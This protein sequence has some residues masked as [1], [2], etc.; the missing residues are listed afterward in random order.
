MVTVVTQ[1]KSF[2]DGKLATLLIF[3]CVLA[4]YGLSFYKRQAS[5]DYWMNHPDEYVVEQVTAMSTH[6]A[7][8]WLKMAEDLDAGKTGKGL[9]DPLKEYPDLMGYPE[10]PSLLARFISLGTNFTGG[11]YYRAGLLLVPLLAGLFVFPL[12]IYCHTLGFGAS[13]ILGG[14]V[15]SFS[16]AYYSRSA[17]GCVDTDL[18]NLFFPLAVSALIVL[19]NRERALRS[20]LLLTLG[21]GL[22]MY[23]YNWWY[24]Q[25]SFILVYLVFIAA[26]LIF[27]RIPWKQTI[28]ILLIFPLACGP[29]YLWQS[30]GSLQIFLGAY[31]LPKTTGGIVWPD[32]MA[33]IQESSTFDLLTKLKGLHDFLPLVFAGMTGLIWLY[34]IRFKQMLPLTPLILIGIWSLVGPVRFTMYLTP[35]I[36]VGAGMLIELASGWAGKKFSLSRRAT[37]ISAIALML[38]VFFATLSGTA[39]HDIPGPAVSAPTVKAFLEIKRTV[40]KHS[41]MLT[42]WSDGYPLME[43]G[44]F[45]TYHDNGNHGGIRSTLIAKALTS[46]RQTDMAALLSYLENYTFESLLERSLEKNLTGEQLV[47]MVFNHPITINEDDVFV[48]YTQGMIKSFEAISISGTWDFNRKISKPMRYTTLTYFSQENHI[49]NYHGGRID[50]NRGI[51]TDGTTVVPLLAALFINNGYVVDRID[52]DAKEGVY[53]QVLI[54]PNQLPQLQLLEEPVY[55]SNFNQQFIL[56]NFDRRYFEEVYN[57]YPVARVLRVR[58]TGDR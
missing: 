42:W 37:S 38:V 7:Y 15:G 34:A 19:I 31:F 47:S 46:Q 39:Y 40:P 55:L 1:L 24:Q 32:V 8:W 20:N 11:D 53:L 16:W 2:P 21:A 35:F 58:S 12:L 49:I 13:A 45:A 48:L 4:V 33:T 14:L 25:P 41:A 9:T 28:L 54:K 26:Y 52:F 5:Y 6:D 50:L 36:G 29:G 44:E 18:L 23:L 3:L 22:M 30:V 43:I 51:I 56:G 57:N 27:T 17:M 10:E